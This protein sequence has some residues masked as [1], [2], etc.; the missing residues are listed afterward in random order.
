MSGTGPGGPDRRP[1]LLETSDRAELAG[2]RGWAGW[3]GNK[4]LQQQTG[5]IRRLTGVQ[6]AVNAQQRGS[7]LALICEPAVTV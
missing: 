7:A 6:R 5:R 4:G 3:G 1:E 2:V